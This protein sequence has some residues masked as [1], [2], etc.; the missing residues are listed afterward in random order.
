MDLPTTALPTAQN[1][2]L[3]GK[4]HSAQKAPND[5]YCLVWCNSAQ[6]DWFLLSQTTAS[7][8]L[9]TCNLAQVRLFSSGH[10]KAASKS[11]I[12]LE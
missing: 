8:Q 10:F 5:R 11:Q 7:L 2:K 1:G 12:K 6:K 9:L 4:S 3:A